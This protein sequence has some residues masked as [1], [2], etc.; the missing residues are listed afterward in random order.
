MGKR[1]QSREWVLKFLYE[2]E[3]NRGNFEKQISQFMERNQASEDVREFA[4]RLIH[5]TI[6]YQK[7]IDQKLKKS[8]DHWELSRMAVVDR[9]ILR[10][11][12]CELLYLSTPAS[13]VIDEAIEIS[14]KYGGEN[15]SEFVNGILDR[16]KN[17]AALDV[18]PPFSAG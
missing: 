8:C 3:L 10:M 6:E 9:N 14:K 2:F 1:R 4:S 16:L 15:S 12:A 5:A 7:I 17:E 11:A 13:I 18:L